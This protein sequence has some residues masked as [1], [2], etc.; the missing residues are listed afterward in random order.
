MAED[1][2]AGGG[3]GGG[4]RWETYP[5]GAR[6]LGMK[7]ESFRRLALRKGWRRNPG[8]DGMARVAIPA[9]AIALRHPRCVAAPPGS[10][11]TPGSGGGA[12]GGTVQAAARDTALLEEMRRRAES[13]EARAEA[14]AAARREAEVLARVQAGQIAELRQDLGRAEGE[15]QVLQ[16]AVAHERAQAAVERQRLEAVQAERDTA[17]AEL[18]EWTGGGPLSRAWRAL[19]YRRGRP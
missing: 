3:T 8:N 16:A 6:L 1:S 18:A 10:D 11:S 4:V 7:V 12:L 13:A 17:R 15:A 5:D 9:E 14:E 2:G 19:V